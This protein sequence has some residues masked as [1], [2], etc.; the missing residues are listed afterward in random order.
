M[1]LMSIKQVQGGEELQ[2]D[3]KA[4]LDIIGKD[5]DAFFNEILNWLLSEA[6]QDFNPEILKSSKL[7]MLV[8]SAVMVNNEEPEKPYLTFIEDGSQKFKLYNTNG[9]TWDGTMFYSVDAE[10]W[11]EWNGGAINSSDDGKLYL[12]GKDNTKVSSGSGRQFIFTDNKQ[13]RCEGNIETI[14]DWEKVSNKESPK[15]GVRCFTNLFTL[16]KS[17]VSAPKLPS[18]ELSYACYGGMFNGCQA[19]LDTPELPALELANGCYTNMFAMCPIT[20]TPKLPAVKLALSCYSGMFSGCKNLTDVPELPA[21]ELQGSCYNQMFRGCTSLKTGFKLPA[22]ALA[23]SCYQDMFLECSLPEGNIHL[24][25]AIENDKNKL[26][27]DS[28]SK[29]TVVYDL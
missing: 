17:L 25:R 10:N 23:D 22:T 18:K 3:V 12:R 29:A 13:I 1:P 16:Q 2:G 9:K 21:L 26:V 28:D 6:P 4:L 7:A 20:S 24:P 14:L 5:K 27:L 19:L 8:S 15:M 11:A